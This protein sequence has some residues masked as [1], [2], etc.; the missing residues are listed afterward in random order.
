MTYAV[1]LAVNAWIVQ[2]DLRI[3]L[4]VAILAA[5]AVFWSGATKTVKKTKATQ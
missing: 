5:I 2:F 3:A 4:G 1:G